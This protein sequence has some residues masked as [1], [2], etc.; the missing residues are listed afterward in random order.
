ML[1]AD[2]NA[3]ISAWADI[4][5]SA[6]G[7]KIVVASG[8]HIDSFVKFKCAGGSGDVHIGRNTYVNSGSVIYTGNG[9]TIGDHVLIAANCTLA[10]VNH[11]FRQRDKL[12]VQQRFRP[13]KGGI[14][15]EDDVWLGAGTVVLDG[16]HIGR[17]RSSP[18]ARSCGASSSRTESTPA[19]PCKRSASASSERASGALDRMARRPA[20]CACRQSTSAMFAEKRVAVSRPIA[21]A[22]AATCRSQGRS[23]W[24]G[25]PFQRF[26]S[27]NGAI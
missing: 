13:T 18:P 9:I 4:E 8:A 21:A 14:V 12:I 25:R 1:I 10:P 26:K 6:R 2:P 27:P 22:L 3:S 19:T 24:E 17:A 23:P 20:L 7:T 15:I 5:Q 11:E 16:A